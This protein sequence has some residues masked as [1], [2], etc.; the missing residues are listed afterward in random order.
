M[1]QG[2]SQAGLSPLHEV[3]KYFTM[4]AEEVHEHDA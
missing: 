3:L 1:N 4:K 2:D